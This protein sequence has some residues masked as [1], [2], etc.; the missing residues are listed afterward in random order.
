M[1]KN[2]RPAQVSGKTAADFNTARNYPAPISHQRNAITEYEIKPCLYYR[3]RSHAARKMHIAALWHRA[4]TGARSAEATDA[5]E[6]KP[7]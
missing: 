4:D 2:L 6:L 1:D 7:R 5:A 3:G